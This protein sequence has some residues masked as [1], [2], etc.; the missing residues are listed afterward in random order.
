MVAGGLP[1][2]NTLIIIAGPTAVGKTSVSIDVAAHFGTEIISADSRQFYRGLTIGTA[3]PSELQLSKVKHHFTGNLQPNEYFNVSQFEHK[4]IDLLKDLFKTHRVVVMSGGS[5]LY[6][7]AVCEGID[8]MPDI[9]KGLR[10]ELTSIY[11]KEGLPSLRKML[12]ELDPVYA[13]RVDLA[14]PTRIIRALEVTMQTGKPYSS[15]LKSAGA[16]R[17]F[18]IIKIALNLPREELHLRISHR[19]DQMIEQGLIDEARAFYHLRHLNSLKTVGYKELFDYFDGKIPL[20]EAVEKIKTNTRRYA[21]RQIT[22]F[23]KDK[24]YNWMPPQSKT[25][26]T[27]LEESLGNPLT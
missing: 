1:F 4:V 17:D 2:K 5:G 23:K 14:N 10:Y 22:W 11:Q 15:H 16:G 26:I 25:V 21:R 9:D 6:I 18:N 24:E 8:E 7:K 19:V 12:F 3:A 27:F 20:D 13:G